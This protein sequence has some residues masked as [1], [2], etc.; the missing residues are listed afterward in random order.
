MRRRVSIE[1]MTDYLAA[2]EKAIEFMLARHWKEKTGKLRQFNQSLFD[3]SLVVLDVML[4]LLPLL[5]G[6]FV[7]QLTE[8]E[9]QVLIAGVLAHDV[10]KELDDWQ[11]YVHGRQGFLSDVNRQLAETVVPQLTGLLGFGSVGETLTGVLLHMS[12]ERTPA[13]VMDRVLFGVHT[14]ERWKT[15]SDLIAEVDNLGSAKGLFEGLRCLEERS[16]FSRHLRT[17]YHLVQM[18]GVSTTML[19][20]AAI[21]AFTDNGWSPV[22]HYSNGTLYATSA[23]SEASEPDVGNILERLAAGMRLALPED[24]TSLVVGSPLQTMI[25][26][27]DLFDHRELR[28]C[29]DVAGRRINRSSFAKKPEKARRKTVTVYRALKGNQN[30]VTDGDVEADTMRIGAGQPEMC[31]FK[32]FKAALGPELLGDQ[33]TREAE[34]LY[35]AVAEQ[36]GKKNAPALTPQD[37]AKAEYDRVFGEGAYKALQGT[38]TLMPARDMFFTVDRFWSLPGARFGLGTP[39]VEHVIDHS[40]RATALID[41]LVMI[42]DRVY[43]SIPDASRPARA[44]PDRI[45]NCFAQDLLHPASRIGLRD[46]AESQLKAYGGTKAN[47]RHDRGMHLCP[48][49]NAT[50][51]KGTVAKADFLA[52]PESHTNRAVSH[53]S[54]GYIVICDACKFERF[55]QQLL[56]GDKVAEVVV[57]FPR[58]NVGHRNGEVLKQKAAAIWDG[59]VMRMTEANPEPDQHVSLGMTF[60]MA[61]RLSGLDVFRLSPEEIVRLLTYESAKE[62]K[63]KN[64][65]ELADQLKQLYEVEELTAEVLNDNW[66]TDYAA[67][68]QAIEALIE[69]KVADDDARK[70]RAAAFRL[71]PQFRIACQTPNLVLVPLTNPISIG[72]ESDTNAGIRELYLMLLLGLALDCSVAVMRL[73]E[74]VTFEGGEG[75]ARVPSVPALRAL[76]GAEWLTVEVAKRWLD[77]IGAAALL[78]SATAFPESSNLYSILKSPTP[79]HVLRRIEQKSDSGLVTADQLRLM[80]TVKEVLR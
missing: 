25:P 72:D 18:R 3:H 61:R 79:G 59:A 45:A 73:G 55:L 69:N 70:A 2:R 41:A 19:H 37:I 4:A 56:L 65:K 74:E 40:R 43:S 38:S 31:I 54:P 49:C 77:A 68:D 78:A 6:T 36:G 33:V 62:T 44:T 27:P 30:P 80:E 53:G 5:R 9:E 47:A 63:K 39:L 50:F 26:K 58:M 1:K 22:L 52:N 24:I 13:T 8:Q 51:E 20:R 12:H 60:N 75:V 15:L 71:R 42:A 21:D 57:M 32:F 35:G 46:I 23:L 14:N 64:R 48:I 76:F 7:P 10:G 34:D 17:S 16:V 67:V 66:A 29:L 28:A 11:E